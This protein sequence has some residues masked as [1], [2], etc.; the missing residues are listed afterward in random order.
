MY[1]THVCINTQF[2]LRANAV[3]DTANESR[4]VKIAQEERATESVQANIQSSK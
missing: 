3:I 2:T 1:K 4:T